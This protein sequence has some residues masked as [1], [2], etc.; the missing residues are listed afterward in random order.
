MAQAV[1]SNGGLPGPGG[2]ADGVPVHT[3]HSDSKPHPYPEFLLACQAWAS[4]GEQGWALSS[5]VG[6]VWGSPKNWARLMVPMASSGESSSWQEDQKQSG[7]QQVPCDAL[8]APKHPVH[9][10]YFPVP[11]SSDPHLEF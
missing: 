9:R 7:H 4:P 1:G 5:G 8:S 6:S 10:A 3:D 2:G 11:P